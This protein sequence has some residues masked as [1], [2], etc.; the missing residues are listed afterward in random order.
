MHEALEIL[1]EYIALVGAGM[2]LIYYVLSLV[3]SWIK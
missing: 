3:F 2:V 1:T